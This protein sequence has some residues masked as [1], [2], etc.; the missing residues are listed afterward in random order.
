MLAF[1]LLSNASV[2][3]AVFGGPV[4]GPTVT[5]AE[6]I[7]VRRVRLK[8]QSPAEEPR[9]SL[10]RPSMKLTIEIQGP[11]VSRASHF[12]MLELE[13]AAD[14]KGNKLKL[15]ESSLGFNDFRKEFVAFDRNHMFFGQENPPKDLVRIELTFEPA[16]REASS[17]SVRGKF[18]LKHVETI[19]ILVAAAV[20]DIKHEQLDKL[21][22]KLKIIKPSR[23]NDISYEASGK[24]AALHDV[25]LIDADGQPVENNGVAS[26]SDS[27][28]LQRDIYLSNPPPPGAKLKVSLVTKA[29]DAP[30]AFDLKDLKLP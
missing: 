24:L 29:E 21:G 14:N 19:D 25:Q 6:I 22:L 30:V 11:E 26:M 17:I 16:V 10:D 12:G 5:A 4:S 8:P 28:T 27:L 7:D 15:D 3:A 18:Q 9:F 23:P 20:G 13:S 1:V 2:V